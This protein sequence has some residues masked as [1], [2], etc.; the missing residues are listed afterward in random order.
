MA[1]NMVLFLPVCGWKV[2]LGFERAKKNRGSV[3]ESL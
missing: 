2:E 1:E 3:G